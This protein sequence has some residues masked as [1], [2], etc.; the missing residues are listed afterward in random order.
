MDHPNQILG[1]LHGCY[2]IG[3][4]ISPLIATSMVT[5]GNL[6]WWTF[7]YILVGLSACELV[8]GT[9]AFWKE[10]GI[11][12]RD[13]NRTD[14]DEKGMTKRAL[15]NRVTWTI[16]IFFLADVGTEG[17]PSLSPCLSTQVHKIG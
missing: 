11:K 6:G 15:K 1:L 13:T 3:A 5:K 2:G 7:Y 12:Y 4:T 10:T 16:S 17:K 14:G 8:V 9:I